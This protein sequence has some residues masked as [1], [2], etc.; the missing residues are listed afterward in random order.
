MPLIYFY[1]DNNYFQHITVEK[2]KK[3]K[4]D[5]GDPDEPFDDDSTLMSNTLPTTRPNTSLF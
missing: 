1:F 4:Q 5:F 3:L 2:L